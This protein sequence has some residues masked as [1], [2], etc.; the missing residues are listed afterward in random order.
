MRWT[1]ALSAGV[2]IFIEQFR[3]RWPWS[4]GMLESWL[5]VSS[6][7][8]PAFSFLR[9][10]SPRDISSPTL[11]DILR[12]GRCRCVRCR[13]HSP[14]FPSLHKRHSSFSNPS[15]VLPTS[16]L[17]LQ[18]FRCFTYITAHSP[19]LLSRLLRHRLF[20]YVTWRAAHGSSL[21]LYV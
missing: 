19:S 15:V 13:A 5:S 7:E 18:S 17:I 21:G 12:T 16:Q 8:V 3:A 4:I 10:P 9:I 1:K 6:S 11:G 20:T 14:T 2:M